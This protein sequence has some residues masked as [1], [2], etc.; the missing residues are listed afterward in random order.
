M[1]N[2]KFQISNFKLPPPARGE[3]PEFAIFNLEFGIDVGGEEA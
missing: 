2:F 3:W 1:M